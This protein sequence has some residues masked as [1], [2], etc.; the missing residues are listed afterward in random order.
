MAQELEKKPFVITK[1]KLEK[2]RRAAEALPGYHECY[3]A[4]LLFPKLDRFQYRVY[5][6]KRA[7]TFDE[8]IEAKDAIKNVFNE[9]D[10]KFLTKVDFE[11]CLEKIIRTTKDLSELQKILRHCNWN[12]RTELA[13][14]TFEKI[15]REHDIDAIFNTEDISTFYSFFN[16]TGIDKDDTKGWFFAGGRFYTDVVGDRVQQIFDLKPKE[17]YGI[18]EMRQ[19]LLLSM[20]DEHY[21][22]VCEF[23]FY[24]IE[25]Y[26][27]D[28]HQAGIQT[29]N[30]ATT[31]QDCL[32]LLPL[33]TSTTIGEGGETL[34]GKIIDKV[35]GLKPGKDELLRTLELYDKYFRKRGIDG[36]R[37]D[38]LLRE[39][40]KEC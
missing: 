16:V 39:V 3:I 31:V 27:K 14:K 36:R 34:P 38:R 20:Y 10:G 17:S 40:L 21:S 7:K 9:E 37:V 32:D 5:K 13:K 29:L 22:T 23:G 25:R 26:A 12:K 8:L 30:A 33:T 15:K 6:V 2:I 35:I 28:L 24:H 11:E 1:D 4:K 19:Y 18:F